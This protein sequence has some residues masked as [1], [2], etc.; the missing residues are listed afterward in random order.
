VPADRV[1]KKARSDEQPLARLSREI[2]LDMK[3]LVRIQNMENPD[4][5]LLSPT[6]AYF[7]RENLRLRLL[8]ARIALLRHDEVTYKADLKPL[9]PGCVVISMS[10]PS[11]PDRAWHSQAACRRPA[12][13]RDAGYFHQ[14]ECG[15]EL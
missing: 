6:Q 2:W 5:P 7:L 8:S 10:R 4:A 14:P 12:Q 13:H 3:Q 9:M 15:A 1:E 11:L